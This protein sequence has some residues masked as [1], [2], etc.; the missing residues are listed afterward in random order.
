M[1]GP[2]L[3][4]RRR[5][6][7]ITKPPRNLLKEPLREPSFSLATSTPSASY[8]GKRYA[9]IRV[10]GSGGTINGSSAFNFS[11]QHSLSESPSLPPPSELNHFLN[12]RSD[13]SANINKRS[14]A[15]MSS[16]SGHFI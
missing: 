9:E 8:K 4:H 15:N 16:G 3:K 2:P 7:R 12:H 11:N 14:E 13:S 5:R 1:T 6:H 10:K